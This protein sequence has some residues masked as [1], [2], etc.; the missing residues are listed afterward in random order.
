MLVDRDRSR[1]QRWVGL[2]GSALTNSS[3]HSRQEIRKGK[4]GISIAA[5]NVQNSDRLSGTQRHG[6]GA[7]AR[8]S[9]A[10]IDWVR[11]SRTLQ[12]VQGR[13]QWKALSSVIRYDKSSR[14]A[15]TTT[16]SAA[17][18]PSQAGNTRATSRGIVDS[19]CKSGGSQTD[20]RSVFARCV[21]W[22]WF[23]PKNDDDCCLRDCVL[24]TKFG[25]RYDVTKPLVLT[26]I[27]QD[28]SAEK[29]V[30]GMFS[31]PRQHASCSSKVV[32]VSAAIANLLHRARMP[33]TVKFLVIRGCGACR[34][35]RLVRHS[36][37]R[38][39]PWRIFAFLDHCA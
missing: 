11:G 38:P 7:S 27:R 15:A 33:W 19:N 21:R 17:P 6:P 1:N 24:D 16:L 10:S 18:A 2:H 9:G 39:G 8:H 32:S 36:F 20:D 23:P 22:S 31:T 14:L 25:P 35:S 29:C 26:R 12:E 37:A 3:P 13:G 34:K 28:V 30:A 4:S 5:A